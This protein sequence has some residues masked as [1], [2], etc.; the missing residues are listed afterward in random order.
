MRSNHRLHAH[1]VVGVLLAAA[2]SVS[3]KSTGTVDGAAFPL[4]DA[5]VGV[6][7]GEVVIELSTLGGLCINQQLATERARNGKVLLVLSNDTG[8]V[9]AGEY[10]V[11]PGAASGR[12]ARGSV[13]VLD[14]R[15]GQSLDPADA[16]LVSGRVTLSTLDVSPGGRAEGT[17]ELTSAGGDTLRGTL[18]APFCEF[19]FRVRL[20]GGAELPCK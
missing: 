6:K 14:A 15:C 7:A 3:V 19:S 10:V 2:C 5:V 16:T 4:R 20:D 11:S 13:Q 18:E 8:P 12:I 1:L 17:F 9:E